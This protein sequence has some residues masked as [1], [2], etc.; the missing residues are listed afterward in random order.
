M[1]CGEGADDCSRC[2]SEYL[3]GR[4]SVQ[5]ASAQGGEYLA[6]SGR[7]FGEGLFRSGEETVGVECSWAGLG[8]ELDSRDASDVEFVAVL[9]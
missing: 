1:F 6:R 5:F 7:A 2:C 8:G 4:F 3:V 9:G